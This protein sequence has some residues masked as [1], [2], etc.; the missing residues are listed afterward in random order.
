MENG[1]VKNWKKAGFLGGIVFFLTVIFGMIWGYNALLH[2]AQNKKDVPINEVVVHGEFKYL[3]AAELES[4]IKQRLDGSFF[5]LDVELLQRNI[6]DDPWIYG[7]SIR[8]EWPQKVHVFIVEQD[9]TAVWNNDLLLNRF[10]DVFFANGV[11]VEETLPKLY[12]PEGKEKDVLKGYVD[13]QYLLDLHDFRISELVLSE[14]YAWQM[15]LQ[16]GIHLNLGRSDKMSRVQRFI[17][18]YPLL[19]QYNEKEVAKIDLRYD[20]GLAVSWQ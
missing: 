6:E 19:E 15:W 1:T 4:R 20:I 2:W 18:M 16:K 10:G 14:R 17:D 3:N 12:G 11:E 9:A 7:V 13:M 8:K 5:S